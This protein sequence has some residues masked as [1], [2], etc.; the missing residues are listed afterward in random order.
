MGVVG[1]C[2]DVFAASIG[3]EAPSGCKYIKFG[4]H[5]RA[6]LRRGPFLKILYCT[7]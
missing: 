6:E 3:G 4:L 1:S 2:S 5:V 7:C